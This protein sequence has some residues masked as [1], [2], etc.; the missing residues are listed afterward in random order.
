MRK[1]SLLFSLFLYQGL[2]AQNV[3]IGTPTPQARLHVQSSSDEVLRLDA[4]KPFLSLFSNGVYQGYFWKGNVG[5]EVGSATGTGLPITFAPD[6]NQK[7]IIKSNGMVGIGTG[8]PTEQL[9][10][11]GAV[12]ATEFKMSVPKTYYYSIDVTSYI[13]SDPAYPAT[14][15][16]AGMSMPASP[17]PIRLLTGV[18]LPHNA[19][20]TKMTAQVYDSSPSMDIVVFLAEATL[21]GSTNGLCNVVSSGSSG[22]TTISTPPLAAPIDNINNSYRIIVD[23]FGNWPGFVLAIR[24]IIIEYTLS[25]L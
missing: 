17:V 9:E 2:I 15:V 18:T 5:I 11:A 21:S 10:V 24:Y 7:M 4:N 14:I 20:V 8:N 23:T 22:I 6:G 25:D 16:P 19:I 3:G 13:S 12:K 1:L